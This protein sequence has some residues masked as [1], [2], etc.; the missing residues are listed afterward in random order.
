MTKGSP[1]PWANR[2][3]EEQE[4]SL[5]LLNDEINTFDHV[6]RSLVDVCGHDELQAEQCA[7]LTHHKGGCV[8]KIGDA[9][10][11]GKMSLRL[12]ELNLD[13]III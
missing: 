1:S 4:K 8:I 11:L 3:S 13:S 2:R 7:L 5:F 10:V 6:I 9:V 12:R